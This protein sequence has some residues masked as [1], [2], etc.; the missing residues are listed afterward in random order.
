[1]NQII[2]ICEAIEDNAR[3]NNVPASEMLTLE[4]VE[5]YCFNA[6]EQYDV[7]FAEILEALEIRHAALEYCLSND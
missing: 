3:I 1:M 4:H 7:D 5:D 6:L 2:K